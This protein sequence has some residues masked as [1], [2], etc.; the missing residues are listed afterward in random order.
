M[1]DNP[2]SMTDEEFNKLDEPNSNE[3]S[4]DTPEPEVEEH[5][6][7]Q[8]T[9]TSNEES[10]SEPE[11]SS[12]N[13]ES[14][15]ESNQEETSSTNT[16]DSGVEGALN[17]DPENEENNDESVNN[18]DNS[19]RIKET[20]SQ[21]DYKAFYDKV[22]APLKANG[23]TVKLRSPE[24]AITLMQKGA[25]YTKRMQ[26]MAPY[27]KALVMLERANLLDED[28][29]S[30]LID[31]H[32]KNPEAI[33][34][35]LNDNNIDTLDLELEEPKEYVPG[36]NKISDSEIQF[37]EAIDEV[38]SAPNGGATITT[39]N[40]WDKES[41]VL[42]GQNP[43]LLR[44]IHEQIQNGIYDTVTN[45]VERLRS[46]G[47][48]PSG[49]PFL[50][51]YKVVGDRMVNSQQINIHRSP[52]NQPIGSRTARPRSSLNNNYR[53][54]QASVTRASS[55]SYQS[56]KNPLAMTDDEFMKIYGYR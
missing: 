43:N 20:K 34:K 25:G 10:T 8:E 50:Q 4:V 53:V 11:S 37:R 51:A 38:S 5:S 17:Y 40:S 9:T 33:R 16:E 49:M 13:E 39:C 7:E 26:E 18:S 31:I 45:E 1:S 2:L 55:P 22:M 36:R 32:N 27:K 56:Y 6:S 29:L 41:K 24:E 3:T 44:I 47:E 35:F 14:S 48:I 46:L 23:K 54:K 12:N 42:L 15:T 19:A 21:I 30:F 52:I 28:Q